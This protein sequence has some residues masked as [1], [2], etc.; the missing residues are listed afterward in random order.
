LLCIAKL[1]NLCPSILKLPS[2]DKSAPKD[3]FCVF[4]VDAATAPRPPSLETIPPPF[5]PAIIFTKFNKI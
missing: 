2:C 5:P 3:L 4:V 1:Y